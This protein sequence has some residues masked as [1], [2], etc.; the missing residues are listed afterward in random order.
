MESMKKRR[1]VLVSL[2][3]E[4]DELRLSIDDVKC[5]GG[6]PVIW[7]QAE[8]VTSKMISTESL[9]QID[10]SEKELADFG[11]YIIARLRAFRKLNEV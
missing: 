2:T 8:H 10:W 5:K 11:Y 4:G 3:E 6:T 1:A 9:E 7:E